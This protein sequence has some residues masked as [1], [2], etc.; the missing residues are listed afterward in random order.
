MSSGYQIETSWWTVVVSHIYPK[1]I[2]RWKVQIYE[3]TFAFERTQFWGNYLLE[4]PTA[5]LWIWTVH[6]II[7]KYIRRKLE[8]V[9]PQSHIIGRMK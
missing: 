2:T 9:K 5:S 3:D 6:F 1:L 7:I 8:A 4:Y